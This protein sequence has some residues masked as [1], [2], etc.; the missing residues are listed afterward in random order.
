MIPLATHLITVKRPPEDPL[1]D[2]YDQP[3]NYVPYVEHVRATIDRYRGT[4]QLEFVGGQRESMK[5]FMVCDPVDLQYTDIIMDEA[6]GQ[7][8]DIAW[9]IQ[10]EN[11]PPIGR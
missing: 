5:L 6:T 10:R 1:L 2:A 8:Y 3:I 9:V 4:G 11:I 7:I